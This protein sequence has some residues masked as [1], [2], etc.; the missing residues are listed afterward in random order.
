MKRFLIAL[1]AVALSLTTAF[2]DQTTEVDDKTQEQQ[3]VE[4]EAANETTISET[5]VET[6]NEPVNDS[7]TEPVSETTNEPSNYP[8]LTLNTLDYFNTSL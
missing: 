7:E 5:I 6:V 4:V 1:F 3:A 8:R 2:A